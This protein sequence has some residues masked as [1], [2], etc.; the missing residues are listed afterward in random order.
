MR[1]LTTAVH[2]APIGPGGDERVAPTRPV[3]PDGGGRWLPIP[4]VDGEA[5]PPVSIERGEARRTASPRGGCEATDG[6]GVIV[7]PQGRESA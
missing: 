3:P 5:G 6:G 1:A 2:S 4:V 7:T